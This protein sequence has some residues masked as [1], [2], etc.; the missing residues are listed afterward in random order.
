MT[1]LRQFVRFDMK[2]LNSVGRVN[3]LDF[4][5]YLYEKDVNERTKIKKKKT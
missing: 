5:F 3:R 2:V 4:Y 1:Q